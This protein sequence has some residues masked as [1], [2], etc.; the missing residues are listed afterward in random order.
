MLRFRSFALT[1]AGIAIRDGDAGRI[2]LRLE[3]SA[4]SARAHRQWIVH[5][6]AR[7]GEIIAVVDLAA[8]KFFDAVRRDD[9]ARAAPFENRVV[10]LRLADLH[11]ILPAGAAA[12]PH[13]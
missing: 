3:G 9:Y 5:L 7:V 8:A 12:A 2:A 4:A 1:A 6:K 11:F 13:S 10:F